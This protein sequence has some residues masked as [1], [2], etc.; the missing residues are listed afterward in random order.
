[1]IYGTSICTLRYHTF[2]H[3]TSSRLGTKTKYMILKMKRLCW[4]QKSIHY[5]R[6]EKYCPP[7]Q[8]WYW[9]RV[10]TT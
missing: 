8:V 3:W 9:I 5:Y 7:T 2:C 10:H 1:M 6:N 4:I